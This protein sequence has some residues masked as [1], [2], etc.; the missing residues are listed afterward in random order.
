MSD[1]L[2]PHVLYSPC[3][4]LGQ[5]I[6]VSGCSLLQGIFPTQGLNPSLLAL[7]ADSLPAKP[8]GKPKNT[9]VGSLSLIQRIFPILELNWGLLHYRQ[10]LSYQGSHLYRK[11]MWIGSFLIYCC[12]C[13]VTQSCP[14]FW[15]PMDCS[16]P[17]FPVLHQLLDLSQTHV[18][19]IGDAIQPSHPLSP[20]SPPAFSLSQHQGLF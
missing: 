10:I 9:G 20:P 11:K 12:C 15:D 18:H 3:N 13:S 16:M 7:Q 4:S 2:L 14:T 8:P 5:N 19:R 6:G 17:G 1:S